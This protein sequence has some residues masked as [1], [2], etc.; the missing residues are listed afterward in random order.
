MAKYIYLNVFFGL[1]F[2]IF[3]RNF[4]ALINAMQNRRN[5]YIPK[6]GYKFNI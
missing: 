1:I 3:F 4:V 6:N 5:N 2:G